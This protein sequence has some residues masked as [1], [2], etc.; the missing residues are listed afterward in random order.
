MS[1]LFEVGDKVGTL[2][3]DGVV[4][5]VVD[6]IMPIKVIVDGRGCDLYFTME[7]RFLLDHKHPSLW[8]KETGTPASVG[9]RPK[10]KPTK[11]TWCWVGNHK[12]GL[13]LRRLVVLCRD[14][15][16]FTPANNGE[17]VHGYEYATPCEA[18]DIPEWWEG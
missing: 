16:Y 10:F 14:G 9:E 15:I 6:D 4:V 1:K 3:G 8:H 12:N 13:S 18:K 2:W 17:C 5:E 11:P 7:G